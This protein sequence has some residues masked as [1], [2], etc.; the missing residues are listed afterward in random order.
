MLWGFLAGKLLE[1][2]K[3]MQLL[4]R[5]VLIDGERRITYEDEASEFKERMMAIIVKDTH[6]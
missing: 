5:I 2:A 6:H 3:K 1:K 4:Q